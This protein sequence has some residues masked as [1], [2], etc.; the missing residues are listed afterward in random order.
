[1][2]EAR[3]KVRV[4]KT[5][6]ILQDLPK[7]LKRAQDLSPAMEKGVDVARGIIEEEFLGSFWFTPSGGKKSWAPR[8]DKKPHPL[9]LKSNNLFNSWMGIGDSVENTTRSS[10]TVGSDL[11]Y[12]RVQR[13][14]SLNTDI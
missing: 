8:K 3:I 14:G 10:F 12:A 4:I 6:K 2:G 9:L 1:M 11:P 7:S 13:G 5:S